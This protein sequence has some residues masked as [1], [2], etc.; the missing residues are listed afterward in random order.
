[1]IVGRERL[2]QSGPNA[3]GSLPFADLP[4]PVRLRPQLC[5]I[6]LTNP[7][8]DSLPDSTKADTSLIA[9]LAGCEGPWV[10][11]FGW[12]PTLRKGP[13]LYAGPTRLKTCETSQPLENAV[14]I[15]L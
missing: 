15:F 5:H 4:P 13:R 10:T 12:E 1:M 11:V 2:G 7:G 3:S 8:G 9:L 6:M 14:L